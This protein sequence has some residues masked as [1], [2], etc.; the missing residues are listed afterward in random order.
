[1]YFLALSGDY[2]VITDKLFRI[3]WQILQTQGTLH[4]VIQEKH[5]QMERQ[6]MSLKMDSIV[7]N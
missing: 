6:N 1:M 4:V 5:S 7:N 2:T 3:K